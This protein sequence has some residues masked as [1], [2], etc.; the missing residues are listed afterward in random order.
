MK[1]VREPNLARCDGLIQAGEADAFVANELEGRFLIRRLGI[2]KDFRM[3]EDPL[4]T[5]A[6]HAHV[7]GSRP[8]S[9]SLL[10]RLN[11]ELR[12]IK[13]SDVYSSVVRA[14]VMAIWGGADALSR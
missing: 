13:Q 10:A 4:E 12:R 5:R 8:N 14:H 1:L 11:Q 7:L 2:H 6:M 9:A 3:L